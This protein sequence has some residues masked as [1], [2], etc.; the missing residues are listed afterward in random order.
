MDRGLG[1]FVC[2]DEFG[3]LEASA[4]ERL[5]ARGRAAGFS[6][7]LGTQTLADLSAAGPAVR[8]RV[9]A[10]VS[11]LIG[12]QWGFAT[13]LSGVVQGLGAELVFALFLYA[14]WRLVP[15]LL[16]L[17]TAVAVLSKAWLPAWRLGDIRNDGLSALGYIAN[18][19]FVWSGQSYFTQ[20]AVPSPL[21]HTWSL[22]IEEQFYLV[23]PLL[24]AGLL[25]VGVHT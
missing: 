1:T 24:V 17:L 16:V 7:A 18:W 9:G 19:R 13:L 15:A 22:A 14:N 6:V 12:T 4:L 10:T 11:A 21:R 3:A 2:V 25:Q 20:G 23:W 5:F 8:E